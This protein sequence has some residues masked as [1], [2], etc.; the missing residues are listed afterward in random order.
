MIRSA[1][2]RIALS[3]AVGAVLLLWILPIYWTVVTSFRTNRDIMSGVPVLVPRDFTLE[4]YRDVLWG[5]NFFQFLVN[6]FLVSVGVTVLTLVLAAGGAFALSRLRFPGRYLV[7][8]LILLVYLFPGV[9]L[10]IPLFRLMTAIGLYNSRLSLVLVD[11]LFTLPFCTW[12]LRVFFDAITPDLEG[13]ALVDGASRLQMLR[14]IYLPLAAPGVA[15]SAIFSF[16]I[17]WNEYMFASILASDDSVKTVSVGI[18]DWVSSYTIDWGS[19]TA[20]AV[21]TVL[22]AIVFFSLLG[23]LFVRGLTMGATKG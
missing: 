7:S 10:V 1:F 22:P 6:S 13:A 18:A 12:T 2:G 5:S 8:N 11:V 3:V 23:K 21:L 4:H 16:V 17:A 15:V 14:H 20:A 19:V 9:L